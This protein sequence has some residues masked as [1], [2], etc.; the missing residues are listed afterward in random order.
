MSLIHSE[1]ILDVGKRTGYIAISLLPLNP[2]GFSALST[3]LR[4]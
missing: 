1:E 4:T 3:H 2:L